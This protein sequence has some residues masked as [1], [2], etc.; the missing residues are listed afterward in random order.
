VGRASGVGIRVASLFLLIAGL[1]FLTLAHAAG[2]RF[3]GAAMNK[4][5]NYLLTAVL[6][7]GTAHAQKRI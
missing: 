7:A 6:L 1:P 2:L 5:G 3:R 4:Y